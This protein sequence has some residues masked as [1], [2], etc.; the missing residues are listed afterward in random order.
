[1]C[2]KSTRASEEYD[3]NGTSR[4]NFR[5]AT[6]TEKETLKIKQ[7]HHFQIYIWKLNQKVNKKNKLCI[8]EQ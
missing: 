2:R 6:A 8:P 4:L 3:L 1:M 5:L 7:E